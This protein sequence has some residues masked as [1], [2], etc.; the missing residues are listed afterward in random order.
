LGDAHSVQRVH[1]AATWCVSQLHD[2]SH[3]KGWSFI[4]EELVLERLI[5]RSNEQ[6]IDRRLNEAGAE[7]KV[8]GGV[9]L[10]AD[11]QAA[12]AFA[13][14]PIEASSTIDGTAKTSACQVSPQAVS[15]AAATGPTSSNQTGGTS[16]S[17]ARG[18]PPPL[19]VGA[20]Q[21]AT[22]ARPGR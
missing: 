21:E 10:E 4:G 5:H 11:L 16:S 12:C 17:V 8:A 22:R 15:P 6:P 7:V 9:G 13:C 19:H 1:A 14:Q 20:R 18:A 2:G 3:R